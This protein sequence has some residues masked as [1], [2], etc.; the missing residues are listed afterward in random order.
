[1]A[2]P[3]AVIIHG[4]PH[5]RTALQQ[6]RAVTLLSAP[7]A[8]SYAGCGWWW[9]LVAAAR[10]EFPAMEPPDVLD[11]GDAPGRALEALSLGCGIIVLRPGP[12]FIDIAGRAAGLGAVVLAAPPRALDLAER[13]VDRRLAAW[14]DQ[15]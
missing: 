8:P 15:A 11:C 12:A 10:D 5:A 2:L 14:L 9:A 1:M 3:P 7:G 4:L 6:G 13:G